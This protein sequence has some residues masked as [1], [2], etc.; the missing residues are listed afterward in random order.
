MPRA[1]SGADQMLGMEGGWLSFSNVTCRLPSRP[2]VPSK[3]VNG[4]GPFWHFFGGST[5]TKKTMDG[6]FEVVDSGHGV[7]VFALKGAG[8]GKGKGKGASSASA[9]KPAA[10][11]AAK[12]AGTPAAGAAAGSSTAT[13]LA[14]PTTA[15]ASHVGALAFGGPFKDYGKAVET[16]TLPTHPTHGY[17]RNHARG[18][19]VAVPGRE[20]HA[21]AGRGEGCHDGAQAPHPPPPHPAIPATPCPPLPP[22]HPVW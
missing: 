18:S 22:P 13:P 19:H 21:G 16:F 4:M 15:T 20:G 2:G 9:A 12:A 5:R 8:G 17:V 11:P 6:R 10:K 1:H 7:K 3:S 14:F